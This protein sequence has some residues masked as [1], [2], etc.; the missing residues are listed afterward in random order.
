MI[1]MKNR[2]FSALTALVM[3]GSIVLPTLP[4]RADD[5]PNIIRDTEIEE[6]L[7]EWTRPLIVAAGLEPSAVNFVIV[8]DDQINAFVAGGQNVFIYTGL[9]EKTKNPGELIGVIAHELGHIRGGHLVRM[10][11]EMQNASYEA[12]LGTVL[13]LGAAIATGNGGAAAVGSVA[14]QSSAMRGFMSFS[15]VQES[16][17]DQS[18]LFEFNEAH[19]NPAGFLT[20]MERLQGQELL[21]D[22]EQ[23]KYVRT[24]PLTRDRIDFITGG[25]TK[26]PYKDQPYPAA[27][28][29]QHARMIAKL[30]GF[31][32]PGKVAFNYDDRDKS[33]AANYAR[34]I[35]AYR[36]NRIEQ[37]LTMM[38]DLIRV[39]P[40]NPYFHELK[41]QMLL[42]Y[43]R[44][45]PSIVELRKAV[46]VKAN[47]PLIRV[48]YA[49]ALLADSHNGQNAG[50]LKEAINQLNNIRGEE[51]RTPRVQHLLATAYGYQ[52]Q[53]AEAKLHLADEASL[54][55]NYKEARRL[56]E[57]AAG[58]LK[59]GS[60][61]WLR[62]QD[63]LSYINVA[64]KD[65]DDDDDRNHNSRH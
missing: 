33:V 32:S 45:G 43:G 3:A 64:D 25:V 35:A 30:T 54:L 13:G 20:F 50:Q 17:A 16:S 11:E 21:P 14:A 8:Q 39:E 34:A 23:S 24:H 31:I 52:G 60:R 27:W 12:I 49:Q 46:G 47:A 38:D 58:Q 37:S 40:Q 4:A 63:I 29:E 2:V 36:Q 57:S 22:S 10:R 26:S 48:L 28:N 65:K 56:A 15:R 19:M 7:K 5:R 41:G 51:D 55:G 1:M 53:E 61:S 44:I 62:A 59:K 42:D 6:T 9:I 18:A